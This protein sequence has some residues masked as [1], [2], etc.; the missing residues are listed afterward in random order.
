MRVVFPALWYLY[1]RY[2]SKKKPSAALD[3]PGLQANG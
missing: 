2:V 1:A 3:V